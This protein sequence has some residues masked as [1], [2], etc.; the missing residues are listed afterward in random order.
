MANASSGQKAKSG[1]WEVESAEEGGVAG[2]FE[3]MDSSLTPCHM[4]GTVSMPA[5]EPLGDMILDNTNIA[6]GQRVT[7]QT[8]AITDGN[9]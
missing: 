9:A 6:I 1:T 8:F 3:I 5:A 4:Q 2:H 7:V